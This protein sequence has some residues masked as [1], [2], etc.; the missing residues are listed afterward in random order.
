M[1]MIHNDQ[2]NSQVLFNSQIIPAILLAWFERKNVPLGTFEYKLYGV[3]F[4]I[5]FKMASD[6]LEN[7]K[8]KNLYFQS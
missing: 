3:L 6:L 5:S 7:L 1:I 8:A 2:L 4:L